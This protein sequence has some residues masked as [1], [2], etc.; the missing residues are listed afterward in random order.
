VGACTG[1][2][3]AGAAIATGDWLVA[4]WLGALA[5]YLAIAAVLAWR[6]HR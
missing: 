1:L 6:E 3:G 2:V 5:A 4:A